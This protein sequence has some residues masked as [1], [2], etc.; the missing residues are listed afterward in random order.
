MKISV[1]RNGN[2]LTVVWNLYVYYN[3]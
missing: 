2:R 1:T 3:D